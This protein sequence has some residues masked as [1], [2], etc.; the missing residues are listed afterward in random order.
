MKISVEYH[1]VLNHAQENPLYQAI[2]S[3]LLQ[4]G[5]QI[6]QLSLLFYSL[7]AR[8]IFPAAFAPWWSFTLVRPTTIWSLLLLSGSFPQ[9]SWARIRSEA[10][11]HRSHFAF[12]SALGS[13]HLVH[14][15]VICVKRALDSS[16]SK[17][18]SAI[19]LRSRLETWYR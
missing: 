9:Y 18:D 3:T 1:T 13:P 11:K 4:R 10:G 19:L 16:F 2:H 17:Y 8:M 6:P 15:A 7:T 5:R 14:M 12:P